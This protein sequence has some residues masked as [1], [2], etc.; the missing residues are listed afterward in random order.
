MAVRK[1]SEEWSR[2]EHEYLSGDDSI[3][4]IADRHEIS[5][6]AIRKRAKLK[7]WERPVR[8]RQPVRTLLPAP[9]IVV[10]DPV[11]ARVPMDAGTI[12]ENARQLVGRML[13]ELDAV[14]SFQGELEE[15]IEILTANDE[16]D[17][18]RDAMMKAVSLPARSQIVKN[19]AASLKVIN[20]TAAPTKG[21]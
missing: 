5:E 9:R 10:A 19:L 18:R 4:E 21:K 15:A 1:T 17:S 2:I 3:R 7:G 11:E 14:T 12:A 16:N 13:D 8:T 6:A 20:E